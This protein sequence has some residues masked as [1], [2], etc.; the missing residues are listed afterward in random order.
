MQPDEAVGVGHPFLDQSGVQIKGV[1]RQ[2]RIRAAGACQFVKVGALDGDVLN[3]A[4]I[5]GSALDKMASLVVAAGDARHGV[6]RLRIGQLAAFH[7][8][9]EDG[10]QV[11]RAARQA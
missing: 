4:S 1:G 5:T 7:D 10:A 9:V 2:N 6:C 8:A 3:A 11:G